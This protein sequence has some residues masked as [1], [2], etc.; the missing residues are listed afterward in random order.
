M[1][2]G[3]GQQAALLISTAPKEPPDVD[4]VLRAALLVMKLDPKLAMRF[5]DR[6]LAQDEFN[7]EA[8]LVR[9]RIH[10]LR[11]ESEEA[12]RFA[13]VASTLD[14]A[15]CAR[16]TSLLNW[17][18]AEGLPIETSGVAE[19]HQSETEPVASPAVEVEDAVAVVYEEEEEEPVL[20]VVEEQPPAP[21]VPV[22]SAAVAETEDEDP[23]LAAV[24]VEPP[25][26]EAPA[27]P[28][29]K[30]EVA[31]VETEVAEAPPLVADEKPVID[32]PALI[33][34]R[35]NS[36]VV[37][38]ASA[39]TVALVVHV[40]LILLLGLLV[41]IVPEPPVAELVGIVAPEADQEQ[42]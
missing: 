20:S 18:A 1:R 5:T 30:M 23:V 15:R 2:E 4:S 6:A 40:I 42:P 35:P 38:K 10:Q 37:Q 26:Q 13:V 32:G 34:P 28:V 14:P 9:A 17:L 22:K 39:I 41:V 36:H 33:A 25:K 29:A 12:H 8:A 16:E 24:A 27:V 21:V 3:S 11:N 7:V 31:K 19:S